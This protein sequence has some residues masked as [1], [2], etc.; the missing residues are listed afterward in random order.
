WG[1]IRMSTA[2]DAVDPRPSKTLYEVAERFERHTL[3][4]VQPLTGRLH[5]IRVHLASAGYPIAADEF[6]SHSAELRVSDLGPE[7]AADRSAA[8]ELLLNRQAL[9]ANSLRFIHPITREL[10]T[11][12]APLAADMQ[13][14]LEVLRSKQPARMA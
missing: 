7:F 11:F 5:Q 13:R 2:P 4:H 12:E 6:Y 8:D 9:H 3:V 10:V 1:T 14:T